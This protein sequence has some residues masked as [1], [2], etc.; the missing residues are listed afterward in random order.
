[1]TEQYTYSQP[2]GVNLEQL[3]NEI[4]QE[5]AIT[6]G[7][8]FIN[9]S[10][11]I[12]DV[13]M[14][15][16]LTGV[17]E[18]ALGN[19]VSGHVVMAL[20]EGAEKFAHD[21]IPSGNCTFS[22]GR[23]GQRW[24]AFFSASGN[25]NSECQGAHDNNTLKVNHP[26][27][28]TKPGLLVVDKGSNEAAI[29]VVKREGGNAPAVNI[30]QKSPKPALRLIQENDG[31]CLYMANKSEVKGDI[32]LTELSANPSDPDK[33]DFW[34]R[35]DPQLP[36]LAYNTASGVYDLRVTEGLVDINVDEA[37]DQVTFTTSLVA[38]R[39]SAQ[40][41]RDNDFYSLSNNNER[42]HVSTGGVYRVTY[43]A[44]SKQTTSDTRST[45]LVG[46]SR[47]GGGG[48]TTRSRSYAYVRNTTDN[49]N[50]SS[51]SFL[52]RLD[53][54]DF[55]ELKFDRITGAGTMQIADGTNVTLEFIRRQD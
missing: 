13:F 55:I 3:T 39:F 47:N 2:S 51:K 34:Y 27:G 40:H 1:M 12:V 26:S 25:F 22:I 32:N 17:E 20:P 8:E 52:W 23:R 41:I 30:I 29:E 7:L 16:V 48:T 44:V 31:S 49:L 4:Q 9:Y 50:S 6:V 11:P 54:G 36:S 37:Q 46:M 10:N 38:A 24:D 35:D 33:G 42:I 18:T 15:G 53:A 43:C 45:V 19:V 28:T 14:S 21:L 5:P